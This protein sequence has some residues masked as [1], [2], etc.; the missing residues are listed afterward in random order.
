M[1]VTVVHRLRKQCQQAVRDGNL[2][3]HL[4][5]LAAITEIERLSGMANAYWGMLRSS[6]AE[7]KKDLDALS[8]EA[9]RPVEEKINEVAFH[10]GK[11]RGE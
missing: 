1:S 11:L 3:L 4:D 7:Q 6:P 8:F 9:V 10:L 2:T 5:L